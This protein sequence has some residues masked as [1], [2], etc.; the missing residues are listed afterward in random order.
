MSVLEGDYDDGS[1]TAG[2]DF[3]TWA[4]L[5]LA[6]SAISLAG[7][8]LWAAFAACLIPL[9]K[10]M[11][12]DDDTS[13][14]SSPATG[15][16]AN[17][18]HT[19]DPEARTV[20][21][22]AN[23]ALAD[24][25]ANA[26]AVSTITRQMSMKPASTVSTARAVAV[27]MFLVLAFLLQSIFGIIIGIAALKPEKNILAVRCLYQNPVVALNIVDIGMHCA[28]SPVRES[29]CQARHSADPVSDSACACV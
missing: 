22:S 25:V 3:A 28:I 20:P 17:A 4:K 8:V 14:G 21:S 24:R 5:L 26:P 13:A 23:P 27:G 19:A 6:L 18:V 11:G 15:K 29:I 2:D 7:M 1:A 9:M 10:K 12:N 16:F